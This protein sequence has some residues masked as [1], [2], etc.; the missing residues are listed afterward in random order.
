MDVKGIG[1]IVLSPMN[2][3][4]MKFRVVRIMGTLVTYRLRDSFDAFGG[5]KRRRSREL[6][7]LCYWEVYESSNEVCN[8]L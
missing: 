6:A 7:R 5:F 4:A 2:D 8:D 1:E 3:L